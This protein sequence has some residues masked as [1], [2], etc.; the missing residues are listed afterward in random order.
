MLTVKTPEEVLHILETAFP[1]SPRPEEVPLAEALGRVLFAPI[2]ATEFVPGF[3][4]STVDGYA[5]RS[6]DTFGCSDALPAIL[7]LQ[8]EVLM[9]EGA[10]R[11]LEPGHCAA[12][13]TGGAM[14]AGSDAAVMVED[15]IRQEYGT[16]RL[17]APAAPWQHIR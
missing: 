17:Y 13:P 16:I 9:G 10:G 7:T 2:T 15:V 14:P 11:A 12:V 8:G 5:V 6:E 4:R 1:P 3:D